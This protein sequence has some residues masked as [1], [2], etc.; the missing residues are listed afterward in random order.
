M[1]AARVARLKG[2]RVT[3]VEASQNLGGQVA[4]AKRAPFLHTIGDIAYWLE[5]EIYRLGVEV[6]TGT[7]MEA[8]EIIAEKPELVA[9]AT[10]AFPRDNGLHYRYPADPRPGHGLSNVLSALHLLASPQRDVGKPAVVV[11]DVG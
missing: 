8:S 2:H 3:L 9:I 4:M 5:Q 11:V 10:G 7:Y 1:E 6:R